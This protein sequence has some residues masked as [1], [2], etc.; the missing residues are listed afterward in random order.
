MQVILTTEVLG[1]G[2]PGEIVTVK[3]G[4]GRNYLIPRGMAIEATK[5]N[6]KAVEAE[7][8][9]IQAQAERQAEQ[10]KSEADSVQ[11]LELTIQAK[12]G[13]SGKLYGS[14]T[15]MD[16]AAALAELG[17]EIDRRR[18]IMDEGPLKSLGEH[19]VPVKLHPQVVVDITV[20]VVPEPGSP[21]AGGGAEEAQETGEAEEAEEAPEAEMGA[22]MGAEM[23]AETEEEAERPA[24][25]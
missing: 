7:R 14:V 15:N 19:T 3:N 13:E 6:V 11:G 12:A 24:G 17:H 10:V 18:I 23:A 4:Y 8:Q 21:A 5:K 20:N 25:E 22:E 1:L 2:D 16:I 9:R